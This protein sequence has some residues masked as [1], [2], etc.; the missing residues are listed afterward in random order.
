MQYIDAAMV[1]SLHT[2]DVCYADAGSEYTESCEYVGDPD[3]VCISACAAFW[4]CRGMGGN[5]RRAVCARNAV[6]YPVA[7]GYMVRYENISIL[8]YSL[9]MS[10]AVSVVIGNENRIAEQEGELK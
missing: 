4:P 6:F 2:V 3:Y 10:D 9:Q 7:V 1:G 8:R 5:V